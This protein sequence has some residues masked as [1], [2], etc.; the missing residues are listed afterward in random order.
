MPGCDDREVLHGINIGRRINGLRDAVPGTRIRWKKSCV[1]GGGRS[2]G[3]RIE[4]EKG[5]RDGAKLYL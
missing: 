2:M 1:K 3:E 4:I 5:F